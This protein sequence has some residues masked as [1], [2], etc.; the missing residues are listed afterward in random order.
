M[1]KSSLKKQSIDS[2]RLLHPKADSRLERK[3][4]SAVDDSRK[5]SDLSKRRHTYHSSA[6]VNSSANSV[7]DYALNEKLERLERLG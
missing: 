5:Q 6:T 3:K 7:N 2:D 1:K 4:S